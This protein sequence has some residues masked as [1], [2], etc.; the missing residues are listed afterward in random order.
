M[1]LIIQSFQGMTK[2]TYSNVSMGFKVLACFF[3]MFDG[4][5]FVGSCVYAVSIL[6]FGDDFVVRQCFRIKNRRQTM[7]LAV[8][9]RDRCI[10]SK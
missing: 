9:L 4:K 8:G 10:I 5:F 3:I 1:M 7:F 6:D 2:L